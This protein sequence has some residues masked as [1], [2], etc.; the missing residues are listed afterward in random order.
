[1]AIDPQTLGDLKNKLEQEKARLKEILGSFAEKDPV[2]AGDYDTRFP[3][4]GEEHLEEAADEVEEYENKLPAEHILELRLKEVQD[5]LGRMESG[6]YGN[7]ASCGMELP[8]DR[9]SANPEAR[10]CI[11]CAQREPQPTDRD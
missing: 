5:A 9:L 2:L 3:N 4:S 8:L 10:F 7:C 11:A 1:M 6:T